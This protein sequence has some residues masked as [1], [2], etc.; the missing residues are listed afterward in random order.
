M[1][2]EGYL[3][4]WGKQGH[5][6]SWMN[7]AGENNQDNQREGVKFRYRRHVSKK[8]ERNSKSSNQKQEQKIQ[9]EKIGIGF[10]RENSNLDTFT[11]Q[12]ENRAK[13]RDHSRSSLI[14]RTQHP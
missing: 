8:K 11:K 4:T 9:Y 5:G 14:Q 3:Y 6:N 7:E 2:G 13:A 1:E 10:Y 12:T